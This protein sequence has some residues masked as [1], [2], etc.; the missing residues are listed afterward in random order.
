MMFGEDPVH[1]I[2]RG[3]NHP[4]HFVDLGIHVAAQLP[5]KVVVGGV[6]EA[7][8]EILLQGPVRVVGQ[9]VGVLLV[10][11]DVGFEVSHGAKP[12]ALPA[13]KALLPIVLPLHALG[14]PRRQV[15]LQRVAEEHGPPPALR[16]RHVIHLEVKRLEAGQTPVVDPM[17]R[18]QLVEQHVELRARV[19]LDV[20]EDQLLRR[21]DECPQRVVPPGEFLVSMYFAACGAQ[22]RRQAVAVLIS[23]RQGSA[24]TKCTTQ[25]QGADEQ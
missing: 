9:G 8:A 14:A 20:A 15:P 6:V 11:L 13:R 7:S 24:C 10:G 17:S 21:V 16:P 5:D 1:V 4:Q 3:A 23:L 19:L 2:L 22:L 25:R 12:A 18:I